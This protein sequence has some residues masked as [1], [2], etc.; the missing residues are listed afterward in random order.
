MSFTFPDQLQSCESQCFTTEPGNSFSNFATSYHFSPESD[1]NSQQGFVRNHPPQRR[2]EANARE[3]D[4]TCSV[5]AAFK[6]LR[7]MIPTEPQTR[8]LSK[9]EILRLAKS[10]IEHLNN[11]R[12]YEC[13]EA[14]CLKD[15]H[16]NH[17]C[18][19][20]L[21]SHKRRF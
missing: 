12:T 17:V 11:V 21:T 16:N 8:K 10:Y 4:R 19:F 15:R 1:N 9:I 2:M 3:R 18:T 13:V 5:N 7:D 6:R 20:C 14:P